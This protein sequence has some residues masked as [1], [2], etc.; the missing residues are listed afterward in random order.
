MKVTK[1]DERI[2]EEMHRLFS[3][4][5]TLESEL[6]EET[7]QKCLQFHNEHFTINHCIRWG[8]IGILEIREEIDYNKK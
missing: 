8:E 3:M 5:A 1:N 6:S 2:L 7:K 4:L